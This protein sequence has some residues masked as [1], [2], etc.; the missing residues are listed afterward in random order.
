MKFTL[1]TIS[2]LSFLSGISQTFTGSWSGN[3]ELP[4][5]SLKIVFNIKNDGNVWSTTMDSPNQGAFGIPIQETVVKGDSLLIND[6]RSGIQ[7]KGLFIDN[8][9][10]GKFIQNNFSF[11]LNL[12]QTVEKIKQPNRP[13]TPQAPFSYK[14]EELTILNT[15]ENVTLS[16]TLTIPNDVKKPSLVILIS[17][18]G[19]QDRDETIFN[20]KPFAVIAD[21]LTQNG[22]ATF[23]F[24]DRGTAKSTGD[25]LKATS[26]NFASDV[27]AIV[28]NLAQRKDINSNKMGLLGHSEGGLIAGIVAAENSKVRFIISMAGPGVNGQDILLEQ[29]YLIGKGAG[30]NM[31][32]LEKNKKINEQLYQ[33]ILEENWDNYQESAQK[34]VDL[35]KKIEI[36]AAN[37]SDQ[38]LINTIIPKNI[39]WF[40]TFLMTNPADY[41]KKIKTPVLAIN[42]ENDIQVNYKQNLP[43]LQASFKNK[44]SQIK[45]YPNLNHLF[46]TSKTQTIAEY[47]EIE[48][49]ISPLILQDIYNWLKF[50]NF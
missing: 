19:P 3:L 35:Y 34:V 38:D 1:V 33:I 15:S 8:K 21:Y 45:S 47:K 31:D 36:S 50:N 43:V 27:N 49:T 30:L 39:I 20:H 42:G 10:N 44:R 26:F 17:G 18:S 11:H 48:E 12:A 5:T 37:S 2:L 29:T 40:K 22:F 13:Q 41:Y 14:T 32:Q 46:Q 24:D 28:N 23:R 4:N 7:Y 16:G 9:I 6:M 25:F